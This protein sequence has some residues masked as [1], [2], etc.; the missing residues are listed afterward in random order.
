M[1]MNAYI[2]VHIQILSYYDSHIPYI[3]YNR[4][5]HLPWSMRDPTWAVPLHTFVLIYLLSISFLS[6]TFLMANSETTLICRGRTPLLLFFNLHQMSVFISYI[7][8][9]IITL[10]NAPLILLLLL[11]HIRTQSPNSKSCESIYRN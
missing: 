8:I 11:N 1:I 5:R 7:I 2:H 10:T 3:N 4:D 6:H 9:Y